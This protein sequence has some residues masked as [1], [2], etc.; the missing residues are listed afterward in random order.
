[1]NALKHG[2]AAQ[3]SVL[4]DED[5]EAF[6]RR[7]NGVMAAL[8]PCDEVELQLA[9]TFVLGTW[10]RDRC[11]RAENSLLAHRMQHAEPEEAVKERHDVTEL[12]RR[13]FDDR[14]GDIRDYPHDNLATAFHD[15][16]SRP[17]KPNDPADPEHILI[18]L[19]STSAGCRWLLEQWAKLKENLAP[20]LSW[21][22]PDKL[23]A[24]RLLGKQPL[25]APDDPE[26]CLIYLASYVLDPLLPGPFHEL[27]QEFPPRSDDRARSMQRLRER[28]W[29]AIRPRTP[30]EARRKLAQLVDKSIARLEHILS[31][32]ENRAEF[33]A[34]KTAARLAFDAGDEA[35]RLRRH[36]RACIRDIFRS[37]NELQKKR[38][39]EGETGR[40]LGGFILG[41]EEDWSS[42]AA[43]P[44]DPPSAANDS[45]DVGQAFQP[46]AHVPNDPP[47]AAQ[48][49]PDV[50]QAFQPDAH[51]PNDPPTAAQHSPPCEA[52]AKH[53]PPCDGGE[54]GGSGEPRVSPYERASKHSPPYEA[55]TQESPTAAWT[56]DPY[57]AAQ[58]STWGEA[59]G[60]VAQP[61]M[62]NGSPKSTDK[63]NLQIKANAGFD[64]EA[65]SDGRVANSAGPDL[66]DSAPGDQTAFPFP[67]GASQA[68]AQDVPRPQPRAVSESSAIRPPPSSR[69]VLRPAST[70]LTLS[71]AARMFRA[72]DA[73]L[74]RR[75]TD[76][77]HRKA[78][79]EDD[80]RFIVEQREKRRQRQKAKLDAAAA[81]ENS[82]PISVDP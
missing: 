19:E 5:S 27:Q 39:I 43:F 52:E 82:P 4:P 35:E 49:S 17:A 25:D 2:L 53:S 38:R 66:H 63:Q 73:M 21:H 10:K 59:P 72:A 70:W 40:N 28:P 1:M 7:R 48:H 71:S 75:E 32:H 30:A 31:V 34:P 76:V 22:S 67:P 58:P 57:L 42:S 74:K 51:V 6:A 55:G 9:D 64:S 81:L 62:N 41:S 12:G 20:G 69:V 78:I 77:A 80:R 16:T 24:V 13:L 68:P 36:Q 11:T 54:R 18:D 15:R 61:T 50:G 37:L 44:N 29:K 79:R 23:R 65:D 45:P 60:P 46:D 56:S 14:R 47:T 26:V 8:A 3:T 33:Y